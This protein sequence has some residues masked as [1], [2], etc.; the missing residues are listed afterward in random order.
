MV[1]LGATGATTPYFSP[2]IVSGAEKMNSVCCCSPVALLL[3]GYVTSGALGFCILALPGLTVSAAVC[4]SGG[5]AAWWGIQEGISALTVSYLWGTN[6]KV[7][8]TC[9]DG[10]H[11]RRALN[12]HEQCT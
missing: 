12:G 2:Q 5:S 4:M 6:P 3:L 9:A 7:E 8:V 1:V 10:M 11:G